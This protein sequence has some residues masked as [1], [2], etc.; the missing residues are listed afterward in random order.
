MFIHTFC[1]YMGGMERVKAIVG[2]SSICVHTQREG[3]E[4]HPSSMVMLGP[5]TPI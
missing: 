3:I 4:H 1:L 2:A 5:Q